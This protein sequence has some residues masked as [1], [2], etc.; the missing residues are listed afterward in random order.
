MRPRILLALALA[1]PTVLACES[2]LMPQPDTVIV[3]TFVLDTDPVLFQW[4]G[5]RATLLADTLRFQ[6]NGTLV[7]SGRTHYDY[8]TLR[9][10]TLYASAPYLQYTNGSRVELELVCPPNA[11][12]GPPPHLWGTLT[13]K[14]LVLKAAEDPGPTLRYRRISEEVGP[15]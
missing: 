12:C 7:R 14:G 6:P 9:D 2:G 3:G 15:Y 10:T 5:V 8:D 11:L 1:V 4:E 13:S